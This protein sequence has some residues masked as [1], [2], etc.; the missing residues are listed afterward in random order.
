VQTTAQSALLQRVTPGLNFLID[1]RRCARHSQRA[2]ER[3]D[4]KVLSSPSIVAMDN[5]PA[6]LQVGDE[7]PITTSSVDAADQLQHTPGE[8]H[9]ERNNRRD[10]ESSAR[11]NSKA[12][13][14]SRSTRKSRTSST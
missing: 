4:V 1:P 12:P 5:Q 3:H 13:S 7:V 11:I 8:H 14:I 2:L 9:R 10:P 6:L